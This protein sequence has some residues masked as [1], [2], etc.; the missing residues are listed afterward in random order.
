[1]TPVLLVH[2]LVAGGGLLAL[3]VYVRL[4][5]RRPKSLAV[6]C[7]HVLAAFVALTLV[8]ATFGWV[9]DEREAGGI[10]ALGLFGVFLPAMTYTFVAALLLFEQLQRRLYGR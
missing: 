7:G 8:P 4:G 6:A 10:L 5:E 9:T 2:A 3:W 1:M